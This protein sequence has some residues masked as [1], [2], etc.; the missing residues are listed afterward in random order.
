MSRYIVAAVKY[1]V[2]ESHLDGFRFE[3]MGIHDIE[4]MNEVTET[5]RTID[6]SIFVYGEGW[7]AGQ[8]PLPYEQQAVKAHTPRLN[9][10]AAF[11]DDLRDG[12]K[13]SVFDHHDRGFVSRKPGLKESIKFGVVASTQ[14][15]QL[16]YA[17][18]NYSEAP[19]APVPA[20][21]INYVSCHDNHTLFDKLSLSMPE[22]GEKE[23]IQMHKLAQ[24]IVLTSGGV[25]FLQGGMEML[26]SKESVENSF[27]SPDEIN[28]IDW[29]RKTQYKGVFDYYQSLIALRKAHPAFRMPDTE[30]IQQH[31]E[32]LDTPDELSLM[33]QI[34]DHANGDAWKDILVI[35]NANHLSKTLSIPEGPWQLVADGIDVGES[36]IK[37]LDSK[38]ITVAP[39]STYILHKDQ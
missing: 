18:V 8:S 2:A 12:L 32:F 33:F 1:G 7:T 14:H 35:Y 5:L 29:N 30:M 4:T 3:L 13:G 21:T 22:A 16:N 31:L 17:A 20:Q 27:E 19:W 6:P 24:S 38:V 9:H 23:L 15:P 25:P 26:R 39:I 10:V 28:Q 37:T 11:S 36:T 34:K